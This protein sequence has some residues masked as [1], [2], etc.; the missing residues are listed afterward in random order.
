MGEKSSPYRVW[1]DIPEERDRLENVNL[2]GSRR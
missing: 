1:V 2:T